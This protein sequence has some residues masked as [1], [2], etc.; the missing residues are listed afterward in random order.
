[1]QVRYKSEVTAFPS[2]PP[3]QLLHPPVL[4][5]LLSLHIETE[6]SNPK[7]QHTP[8]L[9]SSFS[10]LNFS[11]RE[12]EPMLPTAVK[13]EGTPN[14]YQIPYRQPFSCTFITTPH[15][16]AMANGEHL[17]LSSTCAK[18]SWWLRGFAVDVDLLCLQPALQGARAPSESSPCSCT[19]FPPPA[20]RSLRGG[21]V[22]WQPVC[23]MLIPSE[24]QSLWDLLV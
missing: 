3:R 5:P 23:S 22:C 4:H 24:T 10:T 1:M 2:K 12:K 6:L 13:A 15:T 16:W 17:E 20:S 9:P 18:E 19:L 7:E 11:T 8:A 21:D 14:S